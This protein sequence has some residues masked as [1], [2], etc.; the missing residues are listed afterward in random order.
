MDIE[1]SAVRQA[2]KWKR[3]ELSDA[4]CVQKSRAIADRLRLGVDWSKVSTV[5]FFEPIK[6]LME[7]DLNDF[8]SEL[9]DNYPDMRFFT[10]KQIEG[11]WEN[12]ALQSGDVPERFDVVIAPMLGFDPGSKHRIGYGGGFYDRFLANQPQAKKIGVCFAEGR[13][14]TLPVEDHDVPLDTIVTEDSVY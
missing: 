14:D 10:P 9:Q 13:V 6:Q 11:E 7:V 4:D 12:V 5:H 8:I 1:K 3:M 2:L